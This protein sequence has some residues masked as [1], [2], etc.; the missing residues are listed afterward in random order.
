M[1]FVKSPLATVP[2]RYG[3]Y[4]GIIAAA[5]L[6][7]VYY[8]GTHPLMVPAFL[9]F[10]ILLFGLFIFFGVK[11]FREHYHHGV[12]YFWQGMIGSYIIVFIAS[13]VA[14]IG[15]FIFAELNQAFI[16]SFIEQRTA[17]L[18]AFPEEEIKRIGKEVF[19]RNLNAVSATNS[20][21]LAIVYFTQGILIGL[22][23]SIILSVILR[24]QPKTL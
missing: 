22:F 19:D 20:T 24:K 7:A 1:R 6:I 17:F 16:T 8:I 9:D 23:I 5:L 18:K 2:A 10:I 3:L 11:E 12:L 13:A 14:A 21:D 15:L 4:A